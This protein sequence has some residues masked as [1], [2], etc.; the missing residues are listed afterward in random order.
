LFTKALA[1]LVKHP[2][3]IDWP[4][5]SGDVTETHEPKGDFRQF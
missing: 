1:Q 5:E 2:N 4:D 3:G